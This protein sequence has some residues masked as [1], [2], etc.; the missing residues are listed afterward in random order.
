MSGNETVGKTIAVAGMVCLACSIIVSSAAVVLK[1]KQ[2]EN[3]LL[4]K[5]QNILA[6]AGISDPNKSV[7]ELFE[8][9]EMRLV[10]FETGQYVEADNL[11]KYDQR[12]A[13]KDP[14][15]SNPVAAEV[16]IAGIKSQAKQGLVY[17]AKDDSGSVSTI[18]LPVHGYGL[19]STLYGFLALEP[20][21]KTISGLGFYEHA[22]TPGL[23]GEVDNPKWKAQWAGKQLYNDAGEPTTTMYKGTV[24]ANTKGGDYKFDALSGATITSRGVENLMRYW[25]GQHGFGPY[26]KRI[27]MEGV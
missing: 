16:D 27:Q 8:R 14:E 9:I 22:E 24:D 4:D 15:L 5:K 21:A 23:G 12:K 19:W 20:D 11:D 3:K 13:A 1:P 6:A 17:L 10:D 26:L 25:A 18:I 2:T 7:D